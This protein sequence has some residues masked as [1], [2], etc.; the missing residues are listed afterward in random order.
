MVVGI[1]DLMVEDEDTASN[2]LL[3]DFM[4]LGAMVF[5]AGQLTYEEKFVK[6]YN[7]EPMNALGLEGSF[8]FVILSLMLVG[9][10]FI[11]VPFDMGQPDGVLED[12][13][14]GFIQ[15]GHNPVLLVS[16]IGKHWS[17]ILARYS[18]FIIILLKE[19][20]LISYPISKLIQPE[21]FNLG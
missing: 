6:K 16:Y 14:D 11:K 20:F 2:A 13:I 10:Y 7:I 8:S 1:G 21:C 15:L 19:L 18:L 5:Y 17:T 12:A 4:V 9:F 3:G